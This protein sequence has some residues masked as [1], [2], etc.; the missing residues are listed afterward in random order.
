MVIRFKQ[1]I[2]ESPFLKP[3]KLTNPNRKEKGTKKIFGNINGRPTSIRIFNDKNG[4]PRGFLKWGVKEISFDDLKIR[5][6]AQE[7]LKMK[8]PEITQLINRA[9]DEKLI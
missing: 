3:R 5:I 7:L 9:I 6:N 1:F 2:K 4:V 8:K